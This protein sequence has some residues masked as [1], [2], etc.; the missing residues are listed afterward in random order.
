MLKVM[1]ILLHTKC[2]SDTRVLLLYSESH[3]DVMMLLLH[4]ECH[5][6]CNTLQVTLTCGDTL[7]SLF[8]TKCHSY[9]QT[10]LLY[11]AESHCQCHSEV[12]VTYCMSQKHTVVIVTHWM[13]QKHTVEIVTHWMSQLLFHSKYNSDTRTCTFLEHTQKLLSHSFVTVTD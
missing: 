6:Y 10:L 11:Y 13:S 9:I 5:C 7:K 3:N 2:Q 12:T 8:H 4:I 1:V